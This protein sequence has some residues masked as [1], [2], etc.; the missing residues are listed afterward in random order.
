ME[1]STL[2]ACLLLFEISPPC[3][4]SFWSCFEEYKLLHGHCN[5]PARFPAN[6]RLGIWVSAQRQQYKIMNQIPDSAKPRRSAPLT[7]DRIDLLNDIGFTWTIRSRD[8]LGES[9][10]QRLEELKAYKQR[11]EHCLV[12]SRYT[13]NPELGIWVGTQR[14]QYRLYQRAK[15]T[16]IGSTALNEDRIRELEELGFV[17][18]LRGGEGKR[19]DEEDEVVPDHHINN[20]HN[21]QAM[22]P[23]QQQQHYHHQN[24]VE[25]AEAAVGAL[26][27]HHLHGINH[28]VVAEI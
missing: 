22:E 15:E 26:H 28:L 24:S 25:E 10:N 11:E 14:T 8:S 18:A 1:E 3:L 4:F 19:E 7:Q 17:W 9:W 2:L 21:M 13:P 27:H 16:G 12:P 6:R 20:N 23:E 5:V